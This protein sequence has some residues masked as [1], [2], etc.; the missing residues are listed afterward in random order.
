MLS[1]SVY[2]TLSL[3]FSLCECFSEQWLTADCIYESCSLL[4][5]VTIRQSG[6]WWMIFLQVFDIQTDAIYSLT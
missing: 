2:P 5:V 3:L 1:D 4:S 6:L